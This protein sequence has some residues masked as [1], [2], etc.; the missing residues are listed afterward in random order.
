MTVPVAQLS[1]SG[2]WSAAT[3][4]PGSV[5]GFTVTLANTGKVAYTGITVAT[6]P[7]GVFAN[8]TSN[9]DQAATSGTITVTA[10]G[11][12]WTGEHPGGRHGHDHRHGDGE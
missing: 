11:A 8:A 3:A 7:S 5:I 9:G 1:I 2:S 6:D 10:T 12:S 4:T